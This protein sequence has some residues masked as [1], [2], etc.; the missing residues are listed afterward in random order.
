MGFRVEAFWVQGLGFFWGSRASVSC[1]VF[2]LRCWVQVADHR[3]ASQRG[4][5]VVR[6]F[7]LFSKGGSFCSVLQSTS[8]HPR[9]WKLLSRVRSPLNL[10][11]RPARTCSGG[12]RAAEDNRKT[13]R[14]RGLKGLGFPVFQ[15]IFFS[16]LC[17]CLS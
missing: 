4:R 17:C 8:G 15:T 3:L 1:S 5:P 10:N 9:F 13:A 14:T 2:V 12:G 6:V 11:R 16:R 7:C